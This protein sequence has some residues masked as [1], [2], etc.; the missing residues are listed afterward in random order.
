MEAKTALLNKQDTK[1]FKRV[2]LQHRA[3]FTLEKS[4]RGWEDCTIINMDNNL[5]GIGVKFHTHED[6]EVSSIVIIDLLIPNELVPVQIKGIVKWIKGT[7]DYFIGGI[8]LRGKN[9]KI[10]NLLP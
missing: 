1:N 3:K 10:K 5:K 6:I 2:A 9:N 8:E 7:K 4:D